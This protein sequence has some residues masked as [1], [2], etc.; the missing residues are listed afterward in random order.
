MDSY[1]GPLGQ[2]VTNFVNNALLHAFEGRLAGTVI[3]RASPTNEEEVRMTVS[4]DGN[5]IPEADQR[6]IFDPF[7]TTKLGRGGSGLGLNIVYNIVTTVLG[8][9]V[10]VDSRGA[11]TTFTLRMPVSAPVTRNQ[12]ISSATKTSDSSNITTH[13]HDE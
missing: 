5:G 8:G 11:G 7:F 1:P 10:S 13:D 6:R 12:D 2:V 3:I 9:K 4:D